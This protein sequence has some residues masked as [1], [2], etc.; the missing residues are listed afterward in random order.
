MTSPLGFDSWTALGDSELTV[1]HIETRLKPIQSDDLWVAAASFDRLVEDVAVQ[2]ALLELG[3]ARTVGALERAREAY[4]FPTSP[5]ALEETL[6][7][8]LGQEPKQKVDKRVDA[9]TSHFRAVQADA[10]LCQMRDVMLSRLDRLN[11]F[12]E[13]CAGFSE[14]NGDRKDEDDHDG[15]EDD[16]WMEGRVESST[17]QFPIPIPAFLS[18][19]LLHTSCFLASLQY[20]AALRVLFDRH[21]GELWPLRFTILKSIPQHAHPSL[22][23]DLLPG[24]DLSTQR[25]RIPTFTPWRP[26]ADWSQSGEVSKAASFSGA[27]FLDLTPTYG[28]LSVHNPCTALELT[29]WYAERVDDIIL[30]AGLIDVA[31]STIQHG[32]SQGVPGLDELGEE[33]SLLSRLVYDSPQ[34]DGDFVLEEWTIARWRTMDPPAVIRAYLAHSTP[35]TI[36]QDIAKLVVPYLF[37][38]ESHAER[39]NQP[40]PAL[41]T[42][43]LYNYILTAPLEMTAAIFEAS[44]PTLP[45]AQRLIRNDED[46]ARLAL[47]CLYGSDSLD[48][49]GTMS[50]IF[51]CLPAWSIACDDD[52]DQDVTDTLTSLGTFGTPSTSRPPC[53]PSD[54]LAFFRPLPFKSLSRALDILDVHLE[55]GEIMSRWSVS[56]PL[57]WF[58]QSSGDVGEQRAWATRMA[59]RAGGV[60]DELKTQEDWE[61]LLHDMIKLS[62]TAETGCKGVFGL[63][64]RDEV[65]CTFLGGLLSS[66]SE[67]CSPSSF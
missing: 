23:R 33:L 28:R 65:A 59:R 2:R 45:V 9:L 4:M 31:L 55:A 56:A 1:E 27:A 34:W 29:R 54:L 15:W 57:R 39:R 66:G 22:Y 46:M 44:K 25:E 30:S 60:T 6:G 43:L 10:Q 49:W 52:S 20:F 26:D 21:G 35:E 18:D 24:F 37:V 61:W 41:F 36:A 8:R 47:A 51:E 64:T 62:A 12:V 16:P 63:L 42:R 14:E 5:A 48:E 38:L 3:I 50:R 17:K 7:K 11:T 67:H 53:T 40:D 19:D 32:A 58:L 13:I